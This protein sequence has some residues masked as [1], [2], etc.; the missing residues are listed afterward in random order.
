MIKISVPSIVRIMPPLAGAPCVGE[1][2]IEDNTGEIF[3][4]Q[5]DKEACGAMQ[6]A[7]LEL[8]RRLLKIS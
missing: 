2:I 7:F 5:V 3:A 1:V 4:I 8:E 6:Q